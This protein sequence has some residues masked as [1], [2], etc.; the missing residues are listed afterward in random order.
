MKGDVI[1]MLNFDTHT[2]SSINAE[3]T[4][5]VAE[6]GA[7]VAV[8]DNAVYM[9]G[10]W[11]ASGFSLH[12]CHQA[13]LH[14]LTLSRSQDSRR[15]GINSSDV[16]RDSDNGDNEEDVDGTAY[17][18]ESRGNRVRVKARWTTLEG[19]SRYPLNGRDK[20]TAIAYEGRLY[21]FGG[22][23]PATHPFLSPACFN[24]DPDNTITDRNGH[25]IHA[26]GWNNELL[27]YDIETG[28]WDRP[29]YRGYVPFARAA[30]S[31][32]LVGHVAYVIGGR[33][34]N[35]RLNDVY[36][37]DMTT[38]EWTEVAI[39]ADSPHPPRRSWHG[40]ALLA[41]GRTILTYGGMD[42][43][44]HAMNEVWLFDTVDR[45]WIPMAGVH[46]REALHTFQPLAAT[47][48]QPHPHT[49]ALGG[50]TPDSP[51]LDLSRPRGR[52]P[53]L[54]WHTA[55][56]DTAS[57][58]R[59]Y[60][61]G[62]TRQGPFGRA[63]NTNDANATAGHGRGRATRGGRP[64]RGSRREGA[65][66]GGLDGE[67]ANSRQSRLPRGLMRL[68]RVIGVGRRNGAGEPALAEGNG[69]A[70]NNNNG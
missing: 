24:G 34:I 40:A 12:T 47:I 50:T 25:V 45:V 37:L 21:I 6:T 27:M 65:G 39:A 53:R 26:I 29:H 5:P 28:T 55:V 32:T 18:G 57:G 16:D 1:H 22:F 42:T 41:N 49:R 67:V 69:T 64:G 8:Y 3:G 51:P 19:Q 59:V 60:Y 62:G 54:L 4:I 31:F 68:L 66:V 20:T 36:A 44:S 52:I 15:R 48:T 2:W 33:S 17:G 13:T 14:K 9:F 35:G 63:A 46:A 70:N 61:F 38:L 11:S 43:E 23:G 56:A 7:C 30:H 58:G 10:G